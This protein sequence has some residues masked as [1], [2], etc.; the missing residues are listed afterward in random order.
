MSILNAGS[1]TRP[2][3]PT[4]LIV[5]EP[6][7]SYSRETVTLAATAVDR[8]VPLGQ[9]L[10]ESAPG[11]FTEVNLAGDAPLNVPVAVLAEHATVRAN[12]DQPVSVIDTFARVRAGRLVWSEGATD[13]QI[14]AGT[15]ALK[16]AGIKVS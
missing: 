15:A 8:L 11:V 9:V 3:L 5:W 14:A 13:A 16:A 12:T 1:Y 4:D 7:P 2:T 6:E 10:A